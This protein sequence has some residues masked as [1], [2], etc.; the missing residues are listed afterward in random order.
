MSRSGHEL[1]CSLYV[2]QINLWSIQEV[3][4]QTKF[5][6]TES[7]MVNQSAHSLGGFSSITHVQYEQLHQKAIAPS[8]KGCLDRVPTNTHSLRDFLGSLDNVKHGFLCASDSPDQH[9]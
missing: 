4:V 2:T 1:K 8:T 9:R 3:L 6:H 7:F 5:K